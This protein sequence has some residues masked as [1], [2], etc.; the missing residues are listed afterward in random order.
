[1]WKH[2]SMGYSRFFEVSDQNGKG[3]LLLQIVTRENKEIYFEHIS[4]DG[5]ITTTQNM[6]NKN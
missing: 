4:P 6:K 2:S 5:S 3:D 1:M